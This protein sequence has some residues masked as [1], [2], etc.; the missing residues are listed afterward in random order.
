LNRVYCCPEHQKID[1]GLHKH[2][3]KYNPD[4]CE[5]CGKDEG[6]Q[7]CAGCLHRQYCCLEHQK[8][9]WK[10]HKPLCNVYKELKLASNTDPAVIATSLLGHSKELQYGHE[11]RPELA[12]RVQI[13]VLALTKHFGLHDQHS[14]CLMRLSGTLLVLKK[15]EEAEI[16]ARDAILA[17]LRHP[18]GALVAVDML[19]LV[20]LQASKS[21]QVLD[22]CERFL[23]LHGTDDTREMNAL[24]RYKIQAL[25]QFGRHDEALAQLGY[26]RT[27]NCAYDMDW[28]LLSDAQ[29]EMDQLPEAIISMEKAVELTRSRTGDDTTAESRARTL[30]NR[31]GKLGI[32]YVQAGRLQDARRLAREAESLS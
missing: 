27:S 17:E 18:E 10:D 32:L 22:L 4:S 6:L 26:V 31:L 28:S 3:C 13:E 11:R 2:G 30:K 20:L 1:W 7:S 25:S 5:V 12:L 19:A 23:A 16:F 8:E 14:V 29:H 24:R 21:Q 15:F 9:A